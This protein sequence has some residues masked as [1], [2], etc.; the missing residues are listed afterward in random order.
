MK[1]TSVET[2]LLDIPR[3]R[4]HHLSFGSYAEA[5]YCLVRVR[6]DEGLVGL[7]EVAKSGGP[8][9]N[10]ESVET[11]QVVIE[12]YLG[13]GLIGL[14]PFRLETIH[15]RM[16]RFRGNLF[17]KAALEMACWDL[18]GKALGQPLY[19]LIGGLAQERIPLSWSLASGEPGAEIEEAERLI[20]RGHRIFK[21]KVGEHE[22]SADVTRVRQLAEALGGR[23]RLRVDA[24]QGWDEL[25]TLAA[26][27]VFEACA[28]ELLEQ[29]VPRWNL[30][31]MARIAQRADLPIMADE[32]VGTPHD[33]LDLVRRAAADVFAL[34]LAKA[35]GIL[36]SKVVAGIAVAAGLPCYVGCMTE[37]GIG[38]AAYAHFTASTPAV[39][40]GCELFGPLMI[41]EDIVCEPIRYE[42]GEILVPHGPGLGVELDEAQ[43]KRF[44][45]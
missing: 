38:T 45:R 44:Q 39:T 16:G 9:W 14:D 29:P 8:G 40:L 17:A 36:P 28:I 20:E 35:G 32:S 7:G 15:S 24:N 21:V 43:V 41:V 2:T 4:P 6:T 23:A 42:R 18:V 13:P 30:E 26:V 3:I 11:A 34:K 22:P 1:I 19:N 27:P 33:A 10:E 31:A 25:S 37:T 5:S 12:R